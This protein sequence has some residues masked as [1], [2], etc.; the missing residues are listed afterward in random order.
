MMVKFITNYLWHD[1]DAR[2]QIAMSMLK[3]LSS[4]GTCMVGHPSFFFSRRGLSIAMLHSYVSCTTSVVG[5][6]LLLPRISLRYLAYMG[7][8]IVSRSGMLP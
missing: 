3:V 8:C 6:T 5:K 7:T 2:S 4:D 1:A